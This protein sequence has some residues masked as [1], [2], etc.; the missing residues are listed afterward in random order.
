MSVLLINV[1]QIWSSTEFIAAF[2]DLYEAKSNCS[3]DPLWEGIWDS[4]CDEDSDYFMLCKSGTVENN[5]A[6]AWCV[7]NKKVSEKDFYFSK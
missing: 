3:K 1:P 6:E 5:Y 4:Y 2:D 7:Y